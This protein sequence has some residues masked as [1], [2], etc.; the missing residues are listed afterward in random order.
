MQQPP[1]AVRLVTLAAVGYGPLVLAAGLVLVALVL[2][3]VS[4]ALRSTPTLAQVLGPLG[5]GALV[6]ACLAVG[7]LL[8]ARLLPRARSLW[9]RAGAI[10]LG[11]LPLTLLLCYLFNAAVNALV[12]VGMAVSDGVAVRP[13]LLDDLRET[14]VLLGYAHAVILPWALLAAWLLPRLSQRS[15]EVLEPQSHEGTKTT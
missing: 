9:Q 14:L 11:W 15:A 12:G 3:F 8:G 10:Y 4:A 2:S 6:L 13:T 5:L 7:V 1:T